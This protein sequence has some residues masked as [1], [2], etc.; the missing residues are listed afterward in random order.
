MLE[1][2]LKINPEFEEIIPPISPDEFTQLE[3]NIVAEGELLMPIIIWKGFIIDGH[4]RYKILQKHPE[5]ECKIIEKHFEDKYEAIAWICKNQ[6]GS[7]N[8]SERYIRYLRGKQYEAEKKS[9]KFH[10][11]QYTLA[12]ESG[13][14]KFFPDQ[15]SHGTRTL[16]A[17]RNGVPECEVKQSQQFCRGLDAAEEVL[18]GIRKE[19][20]NGTINP[21]DQATKGIA[22][23]PME[24]RKDAAE[25][26][27]TLTDRRS[28]P[29]DKVKAQSVDRI[30]P[31]R[32]AVPVSC[33]NEDD[34]INSIGAAV[35]DLIYLSNN[36]IT[37]FPK[38][39]SDERYQRKT[40]EA[41]NEFRI[42]I[43]KIE[44]K[45]AYDSN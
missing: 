28:L 41:L 44:R 26:L 17:Q 4:S 32:E 12:K 21:T 6:I 39:L 16:I 3:D 10:G 38:L 35:S 11:N 20:L 27:R 14:G 45:N 15:K 40:M 24:K 9:C 1:H 36:Y 8:L 34:I 37:R 30:A 22:R 18:P 23:L 43:S 42:Y 31:D 13:L 19:V 33:V 2:E 25:R 7:R 5:I 29:R